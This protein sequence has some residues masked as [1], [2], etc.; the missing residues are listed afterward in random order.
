MIQGS[1]LCLGLLKRPI[2]STYDV[3]RKRQSRRNS[4]P[5]PVTDP[6]RLACSGWMQKPRLESLNVTVP[7]ARQTV[8]MKQKRDRFRCRFDGDLRGGGVLSVR[9]FPPL[10]EAL[11]QQEEVLK[12]QEQVG[13]SS[14][15]CPTCLLCEVF[16]CFLANL[17]V[18]MGALFSV[19]PFW[20]IGLL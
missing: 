15:T 5:S 14:P 6:S 13:F 8:S 7:G 9:S 10:L 17:K 2:L 19:L 12:A 4:R 16:C 1:Q 20:S 3:L 18:T 11:Q